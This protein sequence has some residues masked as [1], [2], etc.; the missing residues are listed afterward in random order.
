MTSRVVAVPQ[1]KSLLQQVTESLRHSIEDGVWHGYL[2][3]E[4]ELS[5]S[6]HVSR[7]TLRA[8][9]EILARE[10]WIENTP[11]KPRRIVARVRKRRPKRERVVTLIS[12]TPL[13]GM[14]R[15]RLFL[16][17]SLF[18]D[19]LEHKIRFEVL[20]HPGF[21]SARPTH[22]LKLLG[23]GHKGGV[24]LLAQSSK[25]VQ[26][27]FSAGGLPSLVLGS[28]FPGV[29]LPSIECDYPALGRHAAGQLLGRGH[30]HVAVLCSEPSLAGDHETVDSFRG[31][32]ERVKDGERSC[33]ILAYS[34]EPVDLLQRWKNLVSRKPETTAVFAL[35]PLACL[36]IK[37]HLNQAGDHHS[38]AISFLARDYAP[39]CEWTRPTLA[40]Y[41]L[42]LKL[43]AARLSGLIHELIL[44]G[45]IPK[46]H[47]G[48]LP[49]FVPGE[50][51]TT[52][53]SS[54]K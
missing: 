11:G 1:R 20:H 27:W 49:E 24:Y 3:G 9:L 52:I 4:R 14:S 2:P 23:K 37:S 39:H 43:F 19:L 34:A 8:A 36:L 16:F 42:P 15:N 29:D 53:S 7:P 12:P 6:L 50:S 13:Y 10:K 30:R 44:A 48:I 38:S 25:V 40:H 26:N 54:G 47:T 46:K 41:Q 35:N 22:A 17:D 32:I 51:L 5:K 28:V 21:G 33:E 18:Q 45:N 31:E